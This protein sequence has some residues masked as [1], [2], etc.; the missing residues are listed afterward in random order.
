MF[1]ITIKE[2]YV[3]VNQQPCGYSCPSCH[4]KGGLQL[5]VYQKHV[6]VVWALHTVTH[7]TTG[8]VYCEKC[9]SDIAVTSWTDDMEAFYLKTAKESL[10]E[11]AS[12]TYTWFG[13]LCI[14]FTALLLL[15]IA[16]AGIFN[17]EIKEMNAARKLARENQQ[18]IVLQVG[19][20]I[21][22]N[23]DALYT[24]AKPGI[25]QGSGVQWFEVAKE[26]KKAYWLH[27]I[28]YDEQTHQVIA[29]EKNA[30]GETFYELKKAKTGDLGFTV[31][32]LN[33]AEGLYYKSEVT[34][35]VK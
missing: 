30:S 6:D 10:L 19:N 24:N 27:K 21:E 29:V 11:K 12:K 15:L 35:V 33:G 2:K 28:K 7:Q 17:D 9:Q 3:P 1:F 18:D 22:L 32:G 16:A 8:S 31:A 13:K 4:Q 23:Y 14:G 34:Q 25:T 5:T 26:T 20:K